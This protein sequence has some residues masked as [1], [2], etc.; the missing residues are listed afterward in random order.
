[1]RLAAPGWSVLRFAGPDRKQFL[2]GQL[3]ADVLAMKP[4]ERRPALLLTPKGKLRA[5]LELID[6]GEDLAAVAD[7][8]SAAHAREDLGPKL[9][10][11]ETAM[12][13]LAGPVWRDESGWGWGG[14][15]GGPGL[16]AWLTEQGIPLYG[17]DLDEDSLPQE[18]GL[19]AALS[20]TKG[21]YMGQE[22]VSRIHHL[23]RVHRKLVRLRLE[24]EP[25]SDVRLTS[26]SGDR[27]LGW[28]KADK[29]APG[30]RLGGA[31]VLG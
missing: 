9:M 21:C 4:G 17:R 2:H 14:P 22:T 16:E 13:E 27:A 11:S 1:M 26:R 25:S 8:R 30:T 3:T 28:V 31:V 19:D 20:F 15:P 23:G 29:A 24:G 6:R 5:V 12:T 18:T 7:P 10:L